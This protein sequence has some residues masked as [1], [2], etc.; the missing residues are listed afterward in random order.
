MSKQ[1]VLLPFVGQKWLGTANLQGISTGI[2]PVQ[3]TAMVA[4]TTVAATTV[5][6]TTVAAT[7][8]AAITGAVA[9]AFVVAPFDV[10]KTRMQAQSSSTSNVVLCIIRREGMGALW[11]GLRPSLFMTVPAN[12]IY[13][14]A[15]ERIRATI[16]PDGRGS[17]ELAP[18]PAWVGR[19]A[20]PHA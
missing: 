17:D 13:F 18:V 19:V 10:V 15:Y 8:V 20:Q 16:A 2:H 11:S 9:T 6:A 4:A 1:P 7:T 5:A 3:L 14:T 12:V